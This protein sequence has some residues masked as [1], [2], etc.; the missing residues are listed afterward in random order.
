M[1]IPEP[2]HLSAAVIST[3]PLAR[4]GLRAVLDTVELLTVALSLHPAEIPDHQPALQG[5][6]ALLWD[7]GLPPDAGLDAPLP[8][9]TLALARDAA[10]AR[11]A[12]DAGATGVLHRDASP[13]Q[14]SAGLAAAAEGLWVL[15]A[16][17][18]QALV[19]PR[20]ARPALSEP[21]SV[22]EQEVLALLVE[23]L[24][25][26]AIG[27][28][29]CISAHTVKFHVNAI[30]SKLDVSTRTEAAVAAVRLGLVRR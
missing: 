26:P 15:D 21:L 9:R 30:L 25:N 14:L 19:P 18:A 5:V 10:E 12:L 27:R 11:E 23:G 13:R 20:A 3:D 16:R 7:L 28:R 6:D 22:R 17:F 8:A 2:A 1:R 24:S 29:L 4:S